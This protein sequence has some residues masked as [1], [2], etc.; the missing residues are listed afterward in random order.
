[1]N[2]GC[3]R[4]KVPLLGS[5]YFVGILLTLLV[6]PTMG[7]KYGR[8]KIFF[9]FIFMSFFPI[10]AL[11]FITNIDYA[12]FCMFLLGISTGARISIGF[13]YV[14]EHLSKEDQSIFCAFW[15]TYE[16]TILI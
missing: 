13:C 5:T 3:E 10:L 9:Y 15:N 1:M 7:D 2:L 8:R 4:E 6:V 12:I 16:G 11:N 14:S